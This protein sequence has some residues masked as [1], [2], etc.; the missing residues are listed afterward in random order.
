M[1]DNMPLPEVTDL[2]IQQIKAMMET[3]RLSLNKM[4]VNTIH[5]RNRKQSNNQKVNQ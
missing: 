3:N 5:D 4:K 2:A 1:A